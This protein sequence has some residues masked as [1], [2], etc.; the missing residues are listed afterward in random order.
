M[1]IDI[2]NAGIIETNI[3]G[4]ISLHGNLNNTNAGT[5]DM[6][7][8]AL[9]A[10]T[11]AQSQDGSFYGFGGLTSDISM[12]ANSTLQFSGPT[13]VIG[14]VTIGSGATLEVKDGQTLITGYTTNN[15]TIHIKGGT[16]IFQGG[17]TDNGT[18]IYESSDSIN[19]ADFDHSGSVDGQ[20]L[21]IFAHEMGWTY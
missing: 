3:G 19:A 17:L 21:A 13:N 2:N 7:G 8:G 5:V 9:S 15:G 12:D 10:T 1:P 20:D 4:G 11:I 16:V 14:D 18:I 6:K